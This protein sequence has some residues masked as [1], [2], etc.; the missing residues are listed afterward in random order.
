MLQECYKIVTE[1]FQRCYKLPGGKRQQR[2]A[3]ASPNAPVEAPRVGGWVGGH[4]VAKGV[5]RVLQ[6]CHKGVTRVLQGC[7]KGVTRVLQEGEFT[8]EGSTSAAWSPLSW[9]LLL[10]LRLWLLLWWWR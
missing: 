9:Y 2:I 1:V 8:L 5:T 10:F 6:G 3:R 4:G 7:Y